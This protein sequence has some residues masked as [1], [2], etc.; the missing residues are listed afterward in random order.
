MKQRHQSSVAVSENL[1]VARCD[2]QVGQEP[3]QRMP[4]KRH[5]H[6][7]VNSVDLTLQKMNGID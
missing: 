4:P 2:A 7:W 6:D 3:T 1:S 5:D